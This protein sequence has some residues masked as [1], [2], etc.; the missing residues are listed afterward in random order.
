MVSFQLPA[1]TLKWLGGGG[2][3][4]SQWASRKLSCSYDC[5]NVSSPFNGNAN[6]ANCRLI[7]QKRAICGTGRLSAIK[8]N[9]GAIE[10][11]IWQFLVIVV[12]I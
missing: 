2:G 9:V 4:K 8:M 12:V 10:N 11:N 5:P 1:S 6:F 3:S 7:C